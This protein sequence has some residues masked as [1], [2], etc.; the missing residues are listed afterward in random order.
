MRRALRA[1]LEG[2][3]FIAPWL[4]A[5]L[6]FTAGPMLAALGLSLTTWD[7]VGG[8]PPKFV[9]LENYKN[10][11]TSPLVAQSLWVTATYVLGTVPMKVLL[12]LFLALLLVRGLPGTDV[13]RLIFY[14]PTITTGVVLA[15]LW[16]WMYDPQYG[17]INTT[18]GLFGID[19]PPWLKSPDWAMPALIL[20]GS[21]YVG[22]YMVVFLAGLKGIPKE[23]YEAAQ[24]DG[25]GGWSQ[26]R[27][28]TLPML[29]PSIFFNLVM[30][31]IFSFQVFT[32]A[33]VLTGGGP[34]NKTLVYVFLIYREAFN[35]LHMGYA[36]ALAW[37]LFLIV[38]FFTILQFRFSGWVHYEGGR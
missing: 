15:L 6:C 17:L 21:I 37:V 27:H 13:F 36:A 34:V 12:G 18:I 19:G 5:F 3:L 28:I 29:S 20:M 25:A 31:V 4:V 32:E 35:F 33:F 2:Y 1:N 26:F 23:L 16:Q 30:A 9:G 8:A 24:I 11:V 7:I 38:L 22:R 10:L 14:L